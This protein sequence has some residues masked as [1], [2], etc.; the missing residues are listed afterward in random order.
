MFSGGMY[1]TQFFTFVMYSVQ[2]A[3]LYVVVQMLIEHLESHTAQVSVDVRCGIAS[4]LAAIIGIAA[5]SIGPAL[6]EIFNSL[7]RHLRASVERSKCMVRV[8]VFLIHIRSQR[9]CLQADSLS[10]GSPT[11]TTGGADERRFQDTLIKSMGDFAYSL[12]N[13]QK[14]EVM[15]FVLSKIPTGAP[16]NR[17]A[18]TDRYLQHVLV[19]TLLHVATKFVHWPRPVL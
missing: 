8:S 10:S 5:V 12:P 6:L 7:L 16:G 19:K 9:A 15:M 18:E 17:R 11:H 13:Y 4:A 3:Y 1:A 14:F 2:T